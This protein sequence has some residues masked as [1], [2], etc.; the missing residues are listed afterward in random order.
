MKSQSL[1]RAIFSKSGGLFVMETEG[2][3]NL[4]INAF[5]SIEAIELNGNSITILFH[6]QK[7]YLLTPLLFQ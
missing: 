6:T 4:L 1:G 3:G 5:G 7:K 2:E